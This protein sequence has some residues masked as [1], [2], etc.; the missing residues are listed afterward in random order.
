M[1]SKRLK[2]PSRFRKS[3]EKRLKNYAKNAEAKLALGYS[4][5][6]L[7]FSAAAAATLV[8]APA[9]EG[10]II[11]SQ[12][13]GFTPLTAAV[14]PVAGPDSGPDVSIRF[15]VGAGAGSLGFG[16]ISFNS[17]S[18]RVAG[19]YLVNV[20]IS[21]GGNNIRGTW[22]ANGSYIQ[23]FGRSAIIGD[24]I[25]ETFD[26]NFDDPRINTRAAAT[27]GSAFF[28]DG[29]WGSNPVT[30]GYAGFR[31][32]NEANGTTN[33]GWVRVT[34]TNDQE[35]LPSSITIN[36]WAYED[37]PGTPIPAGIPE[38]SEIGLGLGLLA[39]GAAGIRR[40]RKLKNKKGS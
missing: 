9:A 38:P 30:S 31:I 21:Q 23:R 34:V 7:N 22:A 19:A 29:Q 36:E 2:I 25:D 16:N 13:Q 15:P 4:R 18:F 8:A 14:T 27:N 1:K 10:I 12:S 28:Q 11:T 17:Y 26:A 33:Y 20:G 37:S 40:H 39:L 35:N 3:L 32:Q 24:G 6:P 5:R